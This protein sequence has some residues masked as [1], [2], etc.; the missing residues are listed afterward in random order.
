MKKNKF[1]YILISALSVIAVA[2]L[3]SLFVNLG[4]QWFNNLNK[5]SQWVPNFVIPIVWSVIYL[6]TIVVLALWINYGKLPVKTM[7][8][9]ILNGVFNVLWCLLFFTCHLTLL[10]NITIILNLILSIILLLDIFSQNKF[11]GY[12]LTI[13]PIWLC[14]ATSLNL[15]M[16]ILN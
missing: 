1:L 8:L 2:G 13:Y 7:I 15:A 5:P 6:I 10:G 16:W 14:I 12:L 11:Y 4:M 9:F 3:G